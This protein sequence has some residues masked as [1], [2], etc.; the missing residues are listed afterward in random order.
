LLEAP[1][2]AAFFRPFVSGWL[3]LNQPITVTMSHLKKQDF[4]FGRHLKASLKDESVEY[5]RRLLLDNRPAAELVDSDWTMA[6]DILAV[7][8]S[9]P[10]I[11]GAALRKVKQR[12]PR[13]GGLLGHAGI[14][15]MLCWMGD[16]WV[17][18]RG[19]WAL[20]H[21]LDDPPPPPPLDVPELSPFEGEN[22]K[23]TMRDL[24]A[25]HTA[26]RRCSVCHRTMD[27]MGFAFQNFDLSGRWREVEHQ[28]YTR[29]ELDGK[30]EWRG[31]GDTRPVDTVGQ[32]PRGEAFMTF[33]ECKALLVEHYLDDIVRGVLKKLTLYATG[34]KPNALDLAAIDGIMKAHKDRG[35]RMRDLTKAL[36]RSPVFCDHDH[37]TPLTSP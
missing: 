10:A 14:Q 25:Q 3:H 11:E 36:I 9:L 6:N 5:F 12:D 35:Y 28:R 13:G 2:S 17:I 29:N 19:A 15:S 27:P 34:R 32:L 16:N 20:K 23:K 21:I 22:R 26:D 31:D 4:R 18:Y 30:I 24:L 33:A 37:L 7:H 1:P 8:Y